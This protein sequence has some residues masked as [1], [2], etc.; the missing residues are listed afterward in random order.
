[1]SLSTA[2]NIAQSSL[3]TVAAES[4][5]TSRNIAGANATGTY[6]RKVANVVTTPSGS[7]VISITRLQNQALF[8][9]LL[10]ATATSATQSALSDGLTQLNQTVGSV[11]S[12]DTST[13]AGNSPSALLSSFTNALQSYAAQPSSTTLATAAVSAAG[14]LAAGLNSA[15]ATVQSVR[16][17]AD[18]DMTTS[19]STINTLLGQFGSLNTQIMNGSATGSDV[20]DAEDARDNILK[21]LSQQVGITTVAGKNNDISIYTD[22][23]VTLFQDGARSVTMQSTAAYTAAT[24]GKAVY[25]DGIPV[26]GSGATMPISSGKLAG[27]ATLR[28]NT[29]VTYQAQLDQMAG[30]LMTTFKETYQGSGTGPDQAGLFTDGGATTLPGASVTGLAGSISISANVDPSKGGNVNL[31]RDGGISDTADSNYTY[32][33]TG[34]ASYSDRISGLLTGLTAT[35]TFP[36]TGQIETTGTLATY[37]SGSAA[38]LE[39]QRS[40]TSSASSYATTLLSTATTALSNSTGVSLDD[41]M[42]KMLD[43]ENSYSAS[44]KLL[45]TVNSMFSTLLTDLGAVA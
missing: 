36:S 4:A 26:T 12:T 17:Q 41:E 27:L 3:S 1:M 6:S 28:D 35:T 10:G 45:T 30:S 34:A 19:V 31:L 20:T 18:S 16:E 44:A 8:G 23:G 40:S 43:I 37:A 5:V 29:S 13:V 22:S 25:V 7:Q 15:T 14:N 42:S 39:A 2:S 24:T 21:Q 38:W 33:T 11:D 32:N 9:S